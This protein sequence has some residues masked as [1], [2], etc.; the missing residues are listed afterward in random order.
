MNKIIL[1]DGL[2]VGY[3]YAMEF[4]IA[5]Y[6]GSPYEQFI[7][8]NRALGPYAW[9]YWTMVFCNVVAPQLFWFKKLPHEP[10]GDV[11]GLRWR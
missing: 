6:S 7:F 3:A 8:Q 11:R 10:V 2:I 5:W 4:F 9:A 1:A